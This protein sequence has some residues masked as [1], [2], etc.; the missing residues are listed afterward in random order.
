MKQIGKATAIAAV[1]GGVIV[2]SWLFHS[3]GILDSTGAAVMVFVA[4]LLT[5]KVLEDM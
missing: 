4:F 2:L 5:Y 1:W 3:F